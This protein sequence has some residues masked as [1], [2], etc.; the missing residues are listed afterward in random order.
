MP[1][2]NLIQLAMLNP[3]LCNLCG[4]SVIAIG[5]MLPKITVARR[6]LMHCLKRSKMAFCTTPDLAQAMIE[7]GV[8]DVNHLLAD[9]ITPLEP[10][11]AEDG[12]AGVY[13]LVRPNLKLVLRARVFCALM[14]QPAF[15][16]EVLQLDPPDN[17]REAI[18]F[19]LTTINLARE[20]VDPH[21]MLQGEGDGDWYADIL[22]D[23]HS[24]YLQVASD[25]IAVAASSLL[26]ELSLA[27]DIDP[28]DMFCLDATTYERM[29]L[30]HQRTAEL[31]FNLCSCLVRWPEVVSKI[32]IAERNRSLASHDQSPAAH[33]V[34]LRDPDSLPPVVGI[35]GN[36][37]RQEQPRTIHARLSLLAIV[38]RRS[39]GQLSDELRALDAAM[40]CYREK[41][42]VGQ[43]VASM[44]EP[45]AQQFSAFLEAYESRG[46]SFLHPWL[47]QPK[48]QDASEQPVEAQL[49]DGELSDEMM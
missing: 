17:I 6:L 14:F 8:L 19:F 41:L 46:D 24:F 10:R 31:Y 34:V 32:A 29:R 20:V 48:T 11:I 30:L 15:F 7:G 28:V 9:K 33:T 27:L 42:E 4:K 44:D 45:V 39:S 38:E 37:L 47:R 3:T 49:D 13:L 26:Y 36:S 1:S 16:D 12:E 25:E 22:H 40:R 21:R 2:Q 43:L 5:A 18:D 35:G 23:C